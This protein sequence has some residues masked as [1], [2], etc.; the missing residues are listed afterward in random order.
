MLELSSA[1][2]AQG[3]LSLEF[4]E[5]HGVNLTVLKQKTTFEVFS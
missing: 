5:V 3:D 4:A 1:V 2:L